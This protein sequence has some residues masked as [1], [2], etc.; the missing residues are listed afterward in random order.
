LNSER[1][2][3]T[4][5]FLFLPYALS[6]SSAFVEFESKYLPR[7]VDPIVGDGFSFC[8]ILVS[9]SGRVETDVFWVGGVET[10]IS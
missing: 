8:D 9:R 4:V 3:I 2:Y 10:G 7:H 6:L 1:F 5:S